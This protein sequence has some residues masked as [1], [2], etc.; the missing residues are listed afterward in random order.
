MSD[1]EQVVQLGWNRTRK[2][3]YVAVV[4]I[5]TMVIAYGNGFVSG[6]VG[7]YLFIP[8]AAILGVLTFFIS[9]GWTYKLEFNNR[10]IRVRD[11]REATVIP[12]EKIG[13]VVKN[14][15]FIFPKI[16]VVLKGAA[17]GAEL[18]AKSMEPKTRELIDAYQKR[19]PGKKL[20]YVSIPGGYLMSV[21]AFVG[22]LKRRVPP[23]AVDE[24]LS[25]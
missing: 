5:L 8:M 24:R 3:L 25:K 17:V 15:G 9:S 14:R 16:W 19:N 10:E 6:V 12:L 20:T 7:R 2:V 21:G 18:P 11:Q 13:I 23:V 22:E 1:N 4:I